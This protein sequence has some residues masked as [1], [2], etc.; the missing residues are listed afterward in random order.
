M[1]TYHQVYLDPLSRRSYLGSMKVLSAT[2][3][4]WVSIVREFDNGP[5]HYAL[6]LRTQEEHECVGPNEAESEARWRTAL[7]AVEPRSCR[8]ERLRENSP[9]RWFLHP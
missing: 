6:N 2:G 3:G 8:T 5:K 7:E 9:S 4:A 1:E